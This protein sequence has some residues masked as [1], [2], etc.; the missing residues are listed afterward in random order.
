[1]AIVWYKKHN[2]A[3]CRKN[4]SLK[5]FVIVIPKEG[6]A[7]GAPPILLLVWLWLYNLICCNVFPVVHAISRCQCHTKIRIDPAPSAKFLFSMTTT[8]NFEDMFLWHSTLLKCLR[9]II[10]GKWLYCAVHIS[11]P[12]PA[13]QHCWVFWEYLYLLWVARSGRKPGYKTAKST[14]VV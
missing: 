3:V 14:P 9:G 10:S 11:E 4:V 7:D 5:V 6:L 13:P 12:K 1:M 8:K 2:W